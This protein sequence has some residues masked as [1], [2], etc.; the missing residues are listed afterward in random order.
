MLKDYIYNQ[1]AQILII[2]NKVDILNYEDIISFSDNKIIL[3]YDKRNLI[4]NG[5]DL[6]I[7]KLMDDEVLIK[8]NII[9]IEFR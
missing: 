1:K 7:A 5:T 8:G 4:I 6:I 3:K 2:D 9:N